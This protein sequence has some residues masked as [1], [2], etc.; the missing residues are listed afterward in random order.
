MHICNLNCMHICKVL[1]CL[2]EVDGWES[3]SI[4]KTINENVACILA[5]KL[6]LLLVSSLGAP[7]LVEEWTV[8]KVKYFIFTYLILS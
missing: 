5:Q 4:F 2:A 1:F 6:I 8:P 7:G 3:E